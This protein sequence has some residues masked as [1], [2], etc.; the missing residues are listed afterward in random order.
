MSRFERLIRSGRIIV[1]E[2]SYGLPKVY[3]YAGDTSTRL[4]IGKYC[5]IASS[6]TFLIGGNHSMDR[7][8]TYPFRIR[9]GVAGGGRDGFPTSKGDI[10]LGHDVWIGHEALI[11]SG[12]HIGNGAV[13]AARAVVVHD[14][15]AYSMVAGNPARPVGRRTPPEISHGRE[16]LPWWD[17]PR[18]K[19]ETELDYLN[20]QVG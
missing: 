17:W 15:E 19:I 4:E 20:G 1:G 10:R 13:V 7:P 16:D 9:W 6:A 5:S 12:V 18:A 8:S 14:V 3:T 11:L 2:G